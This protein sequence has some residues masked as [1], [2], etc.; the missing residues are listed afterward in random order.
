MVLLGVI[1]VNVYQNPSPPPLP[2]FRGHFASTYFN[3]QRDYTPALFTSPL[4]VS[5]GYVTLLAI[6]YFTIVNHALYCI[7]HSGWAGIFFLQHTP[8]PLRETSSMESR[9]FCEGH[10]SLVERIYIFLVHHDLSLPR[11]ALTLI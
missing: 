11:L 5:W 9:S 7:E 2:P 3:P 1:A 6:S 4:I 8:I 10:F